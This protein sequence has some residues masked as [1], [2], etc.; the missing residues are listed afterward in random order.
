MR[1][2]LFAALMLLAAA[3]AARGE[4]RFGLPIA[5]TPGANC[6]VQNYA[7][8]DSGPGVADH[9]CGAETYDGHD[10]TDIRLRDTAAKAD[11]LAAAAGTVRAIRDGEEDHLVKTAADR[12]AVANR[13]CG[14]GVLIV[15]GDG[16]ETQ[17]CH[18][19]K[20]SVAV[21]AGQTIAAGERLGDVGYSGLAAFPHVHLTIRK[22]GRP[23]DPFAP[24]AAKPCVAP[25]V[26]LWTVEAAAALTYQRGTLLAYGFA[27][28]EVSIESLETGAPGAE[29]LDAA[30][31][32]LVAYGWAINLEAGDVIEVRL[33]GPGDFDT[34]S[35]VVL[36][37]AKAQYLLFAGK[38]NPKA[39]GEYV[40]SFT[41]T[42][43]GAAVIVQRW[44]ATL[45]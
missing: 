23:L 45:P 7:D 1:A 27:P 30:W 2:F 19:K 44:S 12:A 16:W 8:R 3:Q 20:G 34:A 5:C 29:Q 38:R 6:W 10:G 43:N 25:Q 36:D 9:A 32:A 11:V 35:R 33:D 21:R 18:M 39:A 41:V 13:E 17:Y 26:P 14:N 31:P 40:A 42:R 15:H 24:D 37:R 22:D 4:M 28:G